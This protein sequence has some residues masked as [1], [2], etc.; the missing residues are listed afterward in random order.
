MCVVCGL[1]NL[2]SKV[3]SGFFVSALLTIT[4][5]TKLHHCIIAPPQCQGAPHRPVAQT[6]STFD[7]GYCN[8]LATCATLF[9]SLRKVFLGSMA[10]GSSQFAK[11]QLPPL[12][13]PKTINQSGRRNSI[14]KIWQNFNIRQLSYLNLLQQQIMRKVFESVQR[15]SEKRISG[16][17]S[18][19]FWSKI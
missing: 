1:L 13:N 8:S 19:R 2:G 18:G 5:H 10:S 12:Q 16:T 17:M 11:L 14:S 3:C 6:D 15:V 4:A 9:C 7:G